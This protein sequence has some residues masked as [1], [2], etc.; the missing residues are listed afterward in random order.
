[1]GGKIGKFEANSPHFFPYEKFE[2]E[3]IVGHGKIFF[4]IFTMGKKTEMNHYMTIIKKSF[5]TN[6][7]ERN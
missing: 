1:M 7:I 5:D 6:F 3:M 4:E 2:L